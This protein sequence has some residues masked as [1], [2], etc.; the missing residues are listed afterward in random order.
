M[1]VA[2]T[3]PRK[4]AL[5][6]IKALEEERAKL[7]NE[8]KTEALKKAEDAIKELNDLGFNYRLTQGDAPSRATGARRTG[9]RQQIL[10]IIKEHPQGID[11]ATL[12]EKMGADDKA[13][14]QS[15]SNAIAALTKNNDIESP[16][17]GTYKPAGIQ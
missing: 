12:K 1:A 2:E 15:L 13:S 9:I 8:A 14:E 5:D 11:R 7:I 4:T 3:A 10:D 16:S 17:R 6:R